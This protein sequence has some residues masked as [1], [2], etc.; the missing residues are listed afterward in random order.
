MD[1]Q[2][3]CAKARTG[4]HHHGFIRSQSADF[5]QKFGLSGIFETDLGQLRLADGSCH[6]TG[7]RTQQ[8]VSRRFGE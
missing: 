8:A 2:R 6:Q 5:C 7:G 4:Q 3:N 1:G